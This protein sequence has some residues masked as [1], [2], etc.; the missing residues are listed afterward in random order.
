MAFCSSRPRTRGSAIRERCVA[1]TGRAI[2]AV[3]TRGH[4]GRQEP[5]ATW[6]R[7][8]RRSG[9]RAC[10]SG[11]PGP[12]ASA[13][14]IFQKYGKP[15]NHRADK[16]PRVCLASC[17]LY[18][19]SSVS[20][21]MIGKSH[22]CSQKLW[23]DPRRQPALHPLPVTSRRCA[24]RARPDHQT[25]RCGTPLPAEN[26][27]RVATTGETCLVNC[28]RPH[29][30]EPWGGRSVAENV[31]PRTDCRRLS[32]C[33]PRCPTGV[34][35]PRRRPGIARGR[36]RTCPRRQRTGGWTRAGSSRRR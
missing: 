13:A 19:Y 8:E 18:R 32:S 17:T 33:S 12:S 14:P 15:S 3:A 25:N 6:P 30:L 34:T 10:G 36:S 23:L 4:A 27:D 9:V 7:V 29:R 35:W 5:M 26:S 21:R 1:E 20:D 31:V 24:F 28:S 16:H 2:K 11:R 22:C